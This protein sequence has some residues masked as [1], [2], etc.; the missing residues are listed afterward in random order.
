MQTRYRWW[1]TLGVLLIIFGIYFLA[2]AA[3]I[4]LQKNATSYGRG[5]NGMLT[6][7]LGILMARQARVKD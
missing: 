3:Y 1:R 2:D 4:S 6:L 5:I 7:A